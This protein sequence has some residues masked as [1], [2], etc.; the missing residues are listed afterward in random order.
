MVRT[1]A[2]ASLFFPGLFALGALGLRRALPRWTVAD[3][4]LVS[5]RFVSSVQAVLATVSGLIIVSSCTNVITHSCREISEEPPWEGRTK[6][7]P[8]LQS[9]RVTGLGKRPLCG[10]KSVI[11]TLVSR[12]TFIRKEALARSRICLGSDPLHDLRH[13]GHVPLLLVQEQ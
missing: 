4:V 3:C 7:H 13:S 8:I 9:R 1:L 2:L 12:A 11:Q 5:A 6:F 10:R